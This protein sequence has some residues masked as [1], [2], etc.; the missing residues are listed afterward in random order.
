M[1]Q[2]VFTDRRN[3]RRSLGSS[4]AFKGANIGK[5]SCCDDCR[6]GESNLSEWCNL[7]HEHGALQHE[8]KQM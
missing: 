1:L 6:P 8:L 3:Y 7:Q 4:L 5:V 2:D